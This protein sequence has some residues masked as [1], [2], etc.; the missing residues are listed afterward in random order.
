[1]A[2]SL[3][4]LLLTGAS[5]PSQ[6]RRADMHGLRAIV[7][8]EMQKDLKIGLAVGLGLVTAAALWLATRPSL[9]PQARM[10]HLY[11]AGALKEPVVQPTAP[12]IS[13]NPQ[14]ESDA[15]QRSAPSPS[16]ARTSQDSAATTGAQEPDNVPGSAAHEQIETIKTETFYI[17]R[18]GDTLS[19]IS[20]KYYGSASKWPKIFDANRKTISDAN[21]LTP[22]TKLIIPN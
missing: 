6:E 16:S 21:K 19:G 22:G 12:V 2:L 8:C 1:M 4:H 10:Q 17:V 11:D 5:V 13:G 3:L 15:G 20:D 7:L 14:R 18:K 9:T